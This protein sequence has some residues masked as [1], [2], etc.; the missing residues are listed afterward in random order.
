V[1]QPTL[2]CIEVDIA[3]VI[4]RATEWYVRS[5]FKPESE[6]VFRIDLKLVFRYTHPME[7]FEIEGKKRL[8]GEIIVCGSKNATTPL[9]LPRS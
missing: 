3:G 1:K 8:K 9:W 7:V 5:F 6:E 2:S 4:K